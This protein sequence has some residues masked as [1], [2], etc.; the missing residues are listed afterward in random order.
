[1][2]HPFANISFQEFL[3]NFKAS[4]KR[5]Y[6]RDDKIDDFCSTRGI[7]AA[8]L[9]ELM[10]TN[11]LALTIPREYGGFGGNVKQNIA[12]I[13]AASYESLALSLTLGINNAL[14]IQPFTKYGQAA[15]KP[16]VFERFLNNQSMGGLMITE[17][18]FGSDALNMQTAITEKN[19]SYHLQGFKHWQGLTGMAEFWLL[20]GRRKTENG[21][22]MRDVEMFM[23]DVNAPGQQ[24]VV[25]E[26]Y[27]NL[28]L[29]QI[30]YGL[31]RLDVVV[32]EQNRLIP[33]TNGVKMLLDLLH[34]SRFQFPAMGLGFLQRML[35][36][37][38]SHV[39]TRLVGNKS[40]FDYDQVQSRLARLQA[41]FTIC[42]AFC[43]KSGEVADIENDLFPLGLEANIIKTVTTDMMQE[44]AQSLLQLVGGKGYRLNNIAGRSTVDSRPF[45]IFE[46]SNDILYHQIADAFLKLMKTAKETKLY[47]YLV[48]YAPAIA[49]RL[50]TLTSF[51]VDYQ[52]SQRK[53]VEFGQ[54]ISRIFS[55]QLVA[56][57][58][59]RGFRSDLAE[60]ALDVLRQEVSS[61]INNLRFENQTLVVEDYAANSYWFDI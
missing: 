58:A 16:H 15:A 55:M 36:E 44:S 51:E 1:M 27:E 26:Y 33:H 38:I 8:V 52:L 28:G 32:P 7:P 35:D 13:S 4:M 43:V 42:S 6:H 45:Q 59:Q 20:T 24:I 61:R 12:F 23:C 11:P 30:P 25:E 29:Y 49:Q 57:S 19:G 9:T 41:N 22:L 39:K 37:A 31:N 40:L 46:G 10:S 47:N 14:F 54:L 53:L 21:T 60:N 3:D 50:Q 34:R 18:N 17:P 48:S 56:E 2:Q 5:A